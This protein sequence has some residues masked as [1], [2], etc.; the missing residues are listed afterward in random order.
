MSV[1]HIQPLLFYYVKPNYGKSYWQCSIL[2]TVF[3]GPMTQRVHA[4]Q[5]KQYSRSPACVAFVSSKFK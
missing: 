4:H 1:H 2:N 3:Q 5:N